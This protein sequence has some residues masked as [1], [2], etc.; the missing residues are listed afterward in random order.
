MWGDSPKYTST[1]TKKPASNN[2]SIDIFLITQIIAIPAAGHNSIEN[3]QFGLKCKF[4]RFGPSSATYIN[5][6]TILCL[7]PNIQ[8]DPSDIS[9]EE[10]TITVALNGIDYNDDYSQVTFT[11]IGTGGSVST[12]VII[13]GTLIFGVLILAIIVFLGGLQELIKARN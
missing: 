2:V 12:W 1:Q 7:T 6:T 10:V 13:M 8:D 9:E 11:F 5:K 3:E 4:G